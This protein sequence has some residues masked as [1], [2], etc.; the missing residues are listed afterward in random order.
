[1]S[2]AIIYSKRSVLQGVFSNKKNFWEDLIKQTDENNLAI[3]LSK[4]K[5]TQLKYTKI[6]KYLGERKQLNI[7][8]QDEIDEIGVEN[9]K[10]QFQVWECETNQRYSPSWMEE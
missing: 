5:T 8:F 3:R 9:C 7:Y 10:P 6:P 2:K 4:V 1:M